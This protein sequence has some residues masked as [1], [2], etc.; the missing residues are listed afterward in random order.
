LVQ[1]NASYKAGIFRVASSRLA[2]KARKAIVK[3][4]ANAR[5]KPLLGVKG[6]A[7]AYASKLVALRKQRVKRGGWYAYGIQLSAAMNPQRT[8]VAVSWPFRV[9]SRR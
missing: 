5:A 6:T 3:A 7:V 9:K 2:V 4:L 1:E 8:Y